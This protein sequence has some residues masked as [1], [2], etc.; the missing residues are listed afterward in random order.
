VPASHSTVKINWLLGAPR[1][2]TTWLGKIFDSHPDVLY[3]NEPDKELR[4]EELPSMCRVEDVEDYRHVARA[5]L[6]RLINIRTLRS[7]GKRP[8]FL[9]NYQSLR[10]HWLRLGMLYGLHLANLATR[11]SRWPSNQVIPDIIDRAP[12]SPP[13][14]IVKSV[15]ACGRARLYLEALPGSR[16]VLIVRHP[17]AQVASVLRGIALGKFT[18][19]SRELL[20]T[21]QAQQLN[22]TTKRF[23]ALT[24]VEKLAWQWAIL[25]QKAIN[26]LTGLCGARIIR[27]EDL[28]AD[29]ASVVRE[30]FVFAGLIWHP[31][32]AAFI[33]KSTTSN[34]IDRYYGL[35]KK[36]NAMVAKW[37]NQLSFDDECRILGIACSVPVG[38]L[39]GKIDR[40]DGAILP[41]WVLESALYKNS[42]GGAG[43]C[44]TPS[45]T[46]SASSA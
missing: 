41:G 40:N 27:Y 35:K 30:L 23:E 3:R 28:V 2:G 31:Q 6:D 38:R 18:G 16:T 44:S 12:W 24:M 19:P 26:D 10:A 5:Y 21:D 15:S 39:F 34:G 13:T 7:V 33:S 32:T 25:N 36:S 22:L 1:S 43:A 4:S 17:C 11:G 20:S 45:V 8:I 37:R 46:S 29:P 9:K 42:G 14:I